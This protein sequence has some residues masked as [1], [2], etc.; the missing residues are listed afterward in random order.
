MSDFEKTFARH[1]NMALKKEL[2]EIFVISN[3]TALKRD[4]SA[5]LHAQFAKKNIN[6]V[7]G[8]LSSTDYKSEDWVDD[9]TDI[10]F[11]RMA[12]YFETIRG[13]T[14]KN[15]ASQVPIVTN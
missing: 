11:N 5:F 1:K 9:I 2:N 13:Q 6:S 8:G 14:E 12:Q 10:L 3:G 7:H 4:L 15:I